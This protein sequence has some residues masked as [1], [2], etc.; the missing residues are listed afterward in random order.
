[1]NCC[2][3]CS[4]YRDSFTRKKVGFTCSGFNGGLSFISQ[5]KGM[6]QSSVQSLEEA[7]GPSLIWTGALKSLNTP[8]AHGVQCF[9]RCR[10]LTLLE[11]R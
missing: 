10:C 1:M 8:E 5:D 7:L 4:G 2:L 11:N 3:T 9:K 6:S